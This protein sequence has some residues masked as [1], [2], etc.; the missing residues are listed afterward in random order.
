[1]ECLKH[2]G[3]VFLSYLI[4]G[5]SGRTLCFRPHNHCQKIAFKLEPS[6][7]TAQKV[8]FCYQ[9]ANS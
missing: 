9:S 7:I 8:L 5:Y 3:E 4:P 2:E 1:M 6:Q